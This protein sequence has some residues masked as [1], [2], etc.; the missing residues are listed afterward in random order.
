MLFKTDKIRNN[1]S[2]FIT[3]SFTNITLQFLVTIASLIL[4][5]NAIT[6]AGNKCA[7]GAV[8]MLFFGLI[9][10][11]LLIAMIIVQFSIRNKAK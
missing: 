9:F 10:G 7:T 11:I 5:I 6:E 2:Y 1:K 4:A 3:I 8:S